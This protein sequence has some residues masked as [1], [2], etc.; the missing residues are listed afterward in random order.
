MDKPDGVKQAELAVWGTLAVSALVAL[1][2]KWNGAISGGEFAGTLFFYGLL[3]IIPYKIG[4]GSNPA[5]YFYAIVT[6]ISLLL[7]LGGGVGGTRLDWIASVV[8]LPVEVF[9][10][11]RLFQRDASDW[12]SQAR[13]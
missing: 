6:A 5:R 13:S 3:C 9:I 1:I 2:N 4:R 7:M 12:F 11:F 10:V 8:L